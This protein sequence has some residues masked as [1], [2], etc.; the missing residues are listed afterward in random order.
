MRKRSK[1]AVAAA[2]ALLTVAGC[3][4]SGTSTDSTAADTALTI[5]SGRSEDLIGELITSFE[6]E[7]GIDVDVRYG[8]SGELAALLL[9][10]G[11]AS[12][13]D[14]FFSQDAGAL[15]AVEDLLTALPRPASTR[16]TR[17]TART[18]ASGSASPAA[19]AS[20]STTPA[21][22]RRHPRQSTSSSTRSGR[23]RSAS[24]RATPRGSHS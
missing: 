16:S 21:W 22:C 7:S 3:G 1:I 14:V 20:S 11:D 8:D 5:Y 2:M 18:P 12:P 15:G 4:G 23:G 19:C 6:T 24:R 17:S 10:E 9:T 13:A